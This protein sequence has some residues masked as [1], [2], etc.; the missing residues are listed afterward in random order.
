MTIEKIKH[1]SNGSLTVTINGKEWSGVRENSRFWPEVQA[2]IDN[3]MEIE[4][5]FSQSELDQKAQ[6]KINQDSRD[7]LTATDWYIIRNQETG[8]EIPVDILEK[9]QDARAAVIDN[10]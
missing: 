3:G 10:L 7:Y 1:D 9:R 6:D 5:E 2:A 4:P 8:E